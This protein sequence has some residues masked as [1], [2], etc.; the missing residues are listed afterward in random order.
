MSN[1]ITKYVLK[2]KSEREKFTPSEII[3]LI[4][5]VTIPINC[6]L[7]FGITYMMNEY[8]HMRDENTVERCR[9]RGVI[10]NDD[11]SKTYI[12]KSIYDNTKI[13]INENESDN[14][15]NNP[16]LYRPVRIFKNGD[17]E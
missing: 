3:T 17:V 14:I 12:C 1:F 8:Q 5:I 11:Y 10:I 9:I 16:Y 6:A 4:G 13:L 15:D 2:P 7:L